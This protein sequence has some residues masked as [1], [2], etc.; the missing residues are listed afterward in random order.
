MQVIRATMMDSFEGFQGF[1]HFCIIKLHN[2]VS[3]LMQLHKLVSKMTI[4]P[5]LFVIE[6]N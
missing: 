3:H 5:N 2:I 6:K 1:I 4:I